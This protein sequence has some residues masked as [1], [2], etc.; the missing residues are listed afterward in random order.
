MDT[1][2]DADALTFFYRASA[3]THIDRFLTL[4]RLDRG[5]F[6]FERPRKIAFFPGTF[7]PFTLSHKGIVRAIREM[8]F[9]VYLAVDE[10]SWS[11]KPQPHLIRRQIINMSVA[12][13][14]HVYLFPND[15]PVNIANPADLKR[16]REIFGG[17]RLYLVVGADVIAGA[18]AYRKE[19]SPYSIHSMNHIVFSR[20][21]QP[22]LPDKRELHLTGDLME[23]RLPPELEDISSTRIRENVDQN[24]DISHFIDPVIQDFIY[25]NGLYLR[26]SQDKPLLTPSDIAFDWLAPPY[27]GM[28]HPALAAATRHGDELLAI[29]HGD[30]RAGFVTWP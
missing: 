22:K 24:R 17:Q 2:P 25:Q 15:I 30:K 11:K 8:G 7:D 9:E 27:G 5:A 4:Y 1:A 26:D 10:F 18:S 23:L 29:R 21:D 19:P 3:L 20:P 12:G 13:D 16:L 28:E 6:R 14:F